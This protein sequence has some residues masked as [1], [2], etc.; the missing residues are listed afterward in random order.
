MHNKFA[1]WSKL[2]D[3]YLNTT[4][5]VSKAPKCEGQAGWRA[6]DDYFL[7][8]SH[9]TGWSAN[10]M[11]FVTA[12]AP[13]TLESKWRSLGDPT[14]G[15]KDAYNSQSTFVWQYTHPATGKQMLMYMG[16][17]WNYHGKGSVGNATYVWLPLPAPAPHRAG[18]GIAAA[19]PPQ[20][21]P[22]G[23]PYRESWK[24]ADY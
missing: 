3:D 2:T 12:K 24:I 22:A 5:I 19:A 18:G 9:L 10:P 15:S 13:L 17:R 6:G 1:G 4:G 16:D 14:A 23:M 21:G 8:C 11:I 20:A 7:I